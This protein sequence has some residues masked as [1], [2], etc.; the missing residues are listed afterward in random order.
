MSM[1][2]ATFFLFTSL[3][4]FL[5]GCSATKSLTKQELR[6][7]KLYYR[8]VAKDKDYL[9]KPAGF[10]VRPVLE[11]FV[12]TYMRPRGTDGIEFFTETHMMDRDPRY[13][14]GELSTYFDGVGIYDSSDR[15]LYNLKM[16]VEHSSSPYTIKETTPDSIFDLDGNT[17]CE[18][19]WVIVNGSTVPLNG[20]QQYIS[21]GVGASPNAEMIGAI[22][23][24]EKGPYL[25]YLVENSLP[26]N[27]VTGPNCGDW[28]DISQEE[29]AT[30]MEQKFQ[31]FLHQM[32][33]NV[34]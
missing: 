34:K 7:K 11:P 30:A 16:V 20:S 27:R 28:E 2:F 26:T 25:V 15:A 22:V 10:I 19:H 1:L 21:S 33:F 3:V 12:V 23:Q 29:A 32:R 4:L 5:E 17:A 31:Q 8:E 9:V 13:C 14:A 6:L 24:T 18:F